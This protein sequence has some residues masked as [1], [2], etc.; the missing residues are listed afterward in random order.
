MI[1][2]SGRPMIFVHTPK[3]GGSFVAHAV[4]YWRERLCFTRRYKT[5]QGHKT[6][7]EFRDAMAVLGKDIRDYTTFSVIRDPWSWHVSLYHYIKNLEGVAREKKK[8]AHEVMNRLS[9]SEYLL[10]LDNMGEEFQTTHFAKNI[11]DWLV[12]ETG[13]IAVDFVLRQERLVEDLL[14]M[15]K[16][17]GLYLRIPQQRIN[18]SKHDD[19]RSY[20][21]D[22][23]ADFIAR[24][25]RRDIEMFGYTFER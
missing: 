9:F 20:Y 21:T 24:R 12:D 13:E 15:Q 1:L 2:W 7:V 18:T 3:C 10:W 14:K 11:C 16:E 22:Q 6:Y 5:L 8:A 4:G 23:E 19:Y 25:H 17:Y